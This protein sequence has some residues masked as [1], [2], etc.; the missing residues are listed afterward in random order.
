LAEVS[1][2]TLAPFSAIS[3]TSP[4]QT[5]AR[6]RGFTVDLLFALDSG[7]LRT[8]A[9]C[10]RTQKQHQ[11]VETYLNR[12]MEYGLI[13]KNDSFWN[14]TAKGTDFTTYMKSEDEFL[15]GNKQTTKQ[16]QHLEY[17]KKTERKQLEYSILQRVEF[18]SRF[19]LWL[20]N[21]GLSDVEK[22]VVDYLVSHYNKTKQ[23]FILVGSRYELAEQLNANPETV[24][25][26]LAKLYQDR[27]AYCVR[28][29]GNYWKVGLY[30]AF[31]ESLEKVEK[32]P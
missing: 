4:S 7:P 24:L 30:K 2:G 12:M 20:Q 32:E 31:V 8:Y 25:D 23:K 16:T 15:E 3:T 1:Q 26:A 29:R 27:V 11:Y 21:S 6:V 19:D 9:L 5:L 13:M 17:R 10:R 22:G 28:F 18:Q 14:L